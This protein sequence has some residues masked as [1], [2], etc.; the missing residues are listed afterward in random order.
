MFQP[1]EQLSS[2]ELT[3]FNMRHMLT[4]THLIYNRKEGAAVPPHT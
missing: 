1:H 4:R 3:A 2:E